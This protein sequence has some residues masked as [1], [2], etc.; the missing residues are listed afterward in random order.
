MKLEDKTIRELL[1]D[2]GNF[3]QPYNDGGNS[4]EPLMKRIDSAIPILKG[5]ES[6][7]VTD[8]TKVNANLIKENEQL[9][10][11]QGELLGALESC[12]IQIVDDLNAN[13]VDPYFAKIRIKKA[14][15]AINSTKQK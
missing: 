2:C 13:S 9:R 14:N 11:Q 3:I 7:I 4:A 10:K 6:T 12:V 8:N 5:R 1:I 15:Q